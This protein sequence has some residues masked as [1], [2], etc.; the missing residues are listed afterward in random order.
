MICSI[1]NSIANKTDAWYRRIGE[2]NPEPIYFGTTLNNSAKFETIDGGSTLEI[3]N[4]NEEDIGDYC[5]YCRIV[6]TYSNC[7]NILDE[8]NTVG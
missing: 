5:Y 8:N 7:K 4:L 2:S 6:T 3:K 1:N